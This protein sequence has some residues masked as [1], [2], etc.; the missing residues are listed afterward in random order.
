M[1]CENIIAWLQNTNSPVDMDSSQDQYSPD[2]WTA[3][4][5]SITSSSS[6]LSKVRGIDQFNLLEQEVISAVQ[7]RIKRHVL[8]VDPIPN[9]SLGPNDSNLLSNVIRKQWGHYVQKNKECG[10]TFGPSFEV[11][12]F[13]RHLFRP[14]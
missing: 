8:L 5:N 4:P 11:V 7:K 6:R 12:K 13:V 10:V 14:I 3:T 1:N 9:A 2:H